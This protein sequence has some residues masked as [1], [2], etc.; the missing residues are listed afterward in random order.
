MIELMALVAVVGATVLLFF[1]IIWLAERKAKAE[2][3][4]EQRNEN[5]IRLRRSI[6]ADSRA[7][8]RLARGELLHDDGHRRE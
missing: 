5:I 7:R 4:E 1:G 2:L 3:R 8:E 6:E